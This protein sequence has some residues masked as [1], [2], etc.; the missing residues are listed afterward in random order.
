MHGE[1]SV[2]DSFAQCL[3]DEC[4]LDAYAPYSGTKFDLIQNTFDY[5]AEPVR[6]APKK[7]R[8]VSDVFNRLVAAGQ[9]LVGI[10]KKNEGLANKDLGRFADQI[11]SL[12]EKWDR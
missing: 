3:I 9:R 11:N 2:C 1:D 12:C 4:D 6:L 5:E 7:A 8:A 10:I